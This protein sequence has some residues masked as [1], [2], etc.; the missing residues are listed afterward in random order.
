MTASNELLRERVLPRLSELRVALVAKIEA[1]SDS[2]DLPDALL[3]ISKAVPSIGLDLDGAPS[4]ALFGNDDVSVARSLGAKRV[5]RE[6]ITG[7]R[8][9]A[10]GRLGARYRTRLTIERSK[11]AI[12]DV[13]IPESDITTFVSDLKVVI[14]EALGGSGAAG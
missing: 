1:L 11:L 3:G 9:E 14:S 5:A 6:L 12:E 10:K 2:T 8:S 4:G 13:T 7:A